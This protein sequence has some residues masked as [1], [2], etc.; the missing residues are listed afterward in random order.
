[1]K[2]KNELES[3]YRY[4]ERECE[5][6]S[7]EIRKIEREGMKQAMTL[8]AE[9]IPTEEIRLLDEITCSKE[10]AEIFLGHI[11]TIYATELQKRR[12]EREAFR[13]ANPLPPIPVIIRTTEEK[14]AYMA[15]HHPLL[16]KRILRRRALGI[17]TPIKSRGYY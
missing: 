3:S 12:D 10:T 17:T 1:M 8:C 13:A 7:K 9:F 11:R 4:H 15:E 2:T 14:D 16:Y 6:L 5:K